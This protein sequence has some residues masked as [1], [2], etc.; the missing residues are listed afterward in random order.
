MELRPKIFYTSDCEN[1]NRPLRHK[2]GGKELGETAFAK[3][4]KKHIEDDQETELILALYDSSEQ[5]QFRGLFKFQIVSRKDWFAMSEA[6]EKKVA[7]VYALAI[8]ELYEMRDSMSRAYVCCARQ[9]FR[10][11]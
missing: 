7:S 4:I 9:F 11:V 3:A 1:T 8:V 10:Y 5:Y 2:T 6:Q